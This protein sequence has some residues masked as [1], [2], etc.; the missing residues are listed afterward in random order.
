MAEFGVMYVCDHLDMSETKLVEAVELDIHRG[1][2]AGAF[3]V[4]IKWF[5][6][7]QLGTTANVAYEMEAANGL[8]P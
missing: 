2:P 8:R 4:R 5:E 1:L 3:N 6:H 7:H